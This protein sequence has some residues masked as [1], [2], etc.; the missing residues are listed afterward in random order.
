MK[1]SNL[2]S[3]LELAVLVIVVV[4]AL[5]FWKTSSANIDSDI[6]N[7]TKQNE[8]VSIPSTE[9]LIDSGE[10]E[11]PMADSMEE[12]RTI[13]ASMD[14]ALFIGD[15]RTVGLAEY[16]GIEGADFF[17]TVGMS[18]YDVYENLVSVPTVGKVTL[19]E[20]L[21]NKDY[22][23][24]YI[25]LGINEIGYKYD[26]TVSKY[27]ELIEFIKEKESEA[28]IFVQANIHVTQSRS[29]S[30]KVVNNKA[31]NELNFKLSELA[32]S[33]TI[34]YL[35]ANVLFDD[36]NGNLAS[37]KAGDSAHLFAKYYSEWGEWI[38]N[39]TRLLIEEV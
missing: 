13:S 31:I 25:M 24:I 17:S 28:L 32:D 29:E 19:N 30:D 3:L 15:S 10:K 38:I 14:D 9:V 7:S 1:R 34:F 20:L 26:N 8:T 5:F 33:Q 27:K 36:A 2:I 16:A 18:V 11:K 39:Q 4:L 12:K 6:G 22:D 23:K 21:D 37:D 35:D